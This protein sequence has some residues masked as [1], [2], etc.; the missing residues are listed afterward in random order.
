MTMSNVDIRKFGQTPDGARLFSADTHTYVPEDFYKTES[1]KIYLDVAIAGASVPLPVINVGNE[2]HQ[3]WVAYAH[4]L[5][6]KPLAEAAMVGLRDRL[7]THLHP[8]M[9]QLIPG[10]YIT[11]VSPPSL[12]TEMLFEALYQE[13]K[14]SF[15]KQ[16]H[17]VQLIGGY[18]RY[19]VAHRAPPE[20]VLPCDSVI[21]LARGL[22]KFIAATEE[23]AKVIRQSERVIGLDDITNTE[24]TVNRMTDL[25][26][27]VGYVRPAPIDFFVIGTEAQWDAQ[28]LNYPK[29]FPPN[30]HAF[31]Q[32][33]EV[34]GNLP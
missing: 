7:E 14:K 26:E 10:D 18:D 24:T 20:Y 8:I 32:I 5:E 31:F 4:V 21:T 22:H 17:Y 2:E 9:Q 33:P 6:N 12:K 25:T 3:V 1:G 23:Q 28:G 19:D 15:G 13:L 30:V 29:K 11:L 34:I 16:L 27:I